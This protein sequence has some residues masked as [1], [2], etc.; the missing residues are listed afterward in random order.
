MELLADGWLQDFIRIL[1]HNLGKNSPHSARVSQYLSTACQG[2]AEH[3]MSLDNRETYFHCI[4]HSWRAS[5][6]R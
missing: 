4:R 2:D 1:K 5:S 3:D 6:L